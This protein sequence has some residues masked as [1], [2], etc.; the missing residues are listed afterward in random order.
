MEGTGFKSIFV[1]LLLA[2]LAFVAGSLASDS[3]RDALVPSLIVVGLFF[4]VFLGK[5]CWA[6]VLILPPILQVLDFPI[7]QNFPIIGAISA[8]M[9]F[10]W[11]IM[12]VLGYVKFTWNGNKYVDAALLIFFAYF[13]FTWVRHPVTVLALVSKTDF[14]VTEVGGQDYI[15][16][17]GA[18]CYYLF[19]SV[20]PLKLESVLKVLK[21]AFWLSLLAALFMCVKG[22]VFG[23][24]TQS[25]LMESAASSRLG[26]FSSLGFQLSYWLFAKYT[27]VG[28]VL[29]P[30][31]LLLL[32]MAFIGVAL[33]GYRSHFMQIALFITVSSLVHKNLLY[34]LFVSIFAWAGCL[35]LANEDMFDELPYG[36]QRVLSAVPGIEVDYAIT[37]EAQRSLEWRYE[38]WEWAFNPSTG[39]IKDYTFGDGYG[40]SLARHQARH[41]AS[42]LGLIY[43]GDNRFFAEDGIWHSG[44][45]TTIHRIGYVGLFFL[46][47]LILA[48]LINSL[49]VCFILKL[50]NNG[51]YALVS[52]LALIP[53][54]VD[55]FLAA[56]TL[57]SF[58]KGFVLYAILSK[59]LSAVLVR[60]GELLPLFK[61]GEYIPMIQNNNRGDISMLD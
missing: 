9:L 23:T 31:K 27:F 26:A 42:N 15:F 45:I 16:C 38:M 13:L 41:V 24:A 52:L 32:F 57:S 33:G 11:F 48:V 17:L 49:R 21:I 20:I 61:S 34:L 40:Y 59:V 46:S 10:Y 4:L 18:I 1:F 44:Y 43:I 50:Y 14:S 25:E 3:A 37:K 35:F 51:E 2:L 6:L 58:F 7:L 19:L 55:F 36:I 22:V 53:L 5:N 39:Y 29:S 28:I 54:V 30:W 47:V 8:V 56:G 60:K 12:S